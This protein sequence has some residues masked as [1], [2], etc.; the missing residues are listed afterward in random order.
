[1][2][3]PQRNIDMIYILQTFGKSSLVIVVLLEVVP[4]IG[5]AFLA[6]YV[7]S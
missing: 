6:R 3:G 7:L 1:M 4:T 2:N 5:V